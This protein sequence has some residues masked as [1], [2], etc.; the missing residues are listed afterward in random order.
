MNVPPIAHAP[1]SLVRFFHTTV[2]HSRLE[3]LTVAGYMIVRRHFI[4]GGCALVQYT[5]AAD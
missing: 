5:D 2:T 3:R 1:Q 4:C